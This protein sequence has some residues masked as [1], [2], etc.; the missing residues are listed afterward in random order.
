MTNAAQEAWIAAAAGRAV[1]IDGVGG[2]QC[3]DVPKDYGQAIFGVGWHDLWPGAGNACDMINTYSP[4]YFDRI[5]NDPG[6]ASQIPQRGDIIIYAGNAANV[7]GH[8]GVVLAADSGGALLMDQDGNLQRPMATERLGYDNQYTGPCSGWLRPK[9]TADAAVTAQSISVTPIPSPEEDIVASIDDLK[10][11]LTS[12]DVL[13]AIAK[14]VHTRPLPYYDPN[15][16]QD[17][18]KPTT[19]AALVGFADFRYVQTVNGIAGALKQ[20]VADIKAAI[21][22][23]PAAAGAACDALVQKI[24]GMTLSIKAN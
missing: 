1:D 10:N 6:N 22:A 12:P 3:V 17:T 21:A 13:D 15:T 11:V 5:L 20:A 16:G 9:V 4:T 23:D 8:I 2:F 7:Y 19:V 18:G 24:D 14:T